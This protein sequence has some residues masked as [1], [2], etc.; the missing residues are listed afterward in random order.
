MR[1]ATIVGAHI[2]RSR[3]KPRERRARTRISPAA[4][5]RGA[6]PSLVALEH[7]HLVT[8]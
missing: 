8:A 1:R 7:P 5:A 6:S 3:E 4:V 2:G